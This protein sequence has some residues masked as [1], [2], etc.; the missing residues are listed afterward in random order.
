MTLTGTGT[1]TLSGTANT[2]TGEVAVNSGMLDFTAGNASA[3]A[4]QVLGENANLTLGV[5][6][7]SSG[8]LNSTGAAGTLAKG[9][10]AR[11]NGNDTIENSGTGV[12]TLTGG[13][14]KN[15]T[16]LTLNAAAKGITV[17]TIGISGSSANSDMDFTGTGGPITLSVA[18][19]YNGPTWIYGGGDVVAAVANA[20]PTTTSLNIGTPGAAGV[21]TRSTTTSGT[22]DLDGNNQTVAGL[23]TEGTGPYTSDIVTNN[24]GTTETLTVTGGGTFAGVIQNGTHTTALAIT[25]GVQTLSGANTYTGTTTVASG[26]L[27]LIGSLASGSAVTVGN[28]TGV[29]MVEGT[30]TISGALSTSTTGSNIAYVA[31]GA[32]GTVGT[33]NVGSLGF[34]IGAGTQFDYAINTST[35]VGGSSNGLIA[36]TGGTLS[37]GGTGIVFNFDQISSLTTGTAYTLIDGA[38]TISGFSASDFSATGIGSDTATFSENDGDTAILVTINSASTPKYNFTGTNSNTFTDPGNYFTAASSGSQQGTAL[39]STS[40]VFLNATSPTPVNTPDTLNGTQEINSLTLLT[41]GTAGSLAGTGTLGLVAGITDS[42][43]GGSTESISPAVQLYGPQTWTV[44]SSTNTLTLSGAISDGSG[45]NSL[46]L[47]GPGT[48]KFSNGSST[49][50]WRHVTDLRH[51]VAHQ[52]Q[53][54]ICSRYRFPERG[55]GCYHRRFG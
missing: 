44:S 28:N 30:G 32:V 49:L 36:M 35:A 33:L 21:A 6:S 31:P 38:T 7:T 46:T 29:A 20:L 24:G 48:F 9:I 51:A 19:T 22:F 37:I 53:R 4:A 40:N 18:S 16:T 43:T 52:Y 55:G 3:T 11:G 50:R 23:N 2:F 14:V 1:Q 17:S 26:T 12:L 10:S 34:T 27:N 25:G 45:T 47:T 8:T 42:A 39:S 13:L 41:G 5:A 54:H 15:G